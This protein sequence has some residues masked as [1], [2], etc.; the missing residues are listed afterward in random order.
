[1]VASQLQLLCRLG[2]SGGAGKPEG[3]LG[4]CPGVCGWDGVF[5][6]HGALGGLGK[7]ESVHLLNKDLI[8]NSWRIH[9]TEYRPECLARERHPQHAV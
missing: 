9:E 1:M 8:N 7:G 4:S 6:I 2:L 3:E 5:W